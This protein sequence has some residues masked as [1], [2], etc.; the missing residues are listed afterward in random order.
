MFRYRQISGN[1]GG[2]QSLGISH[3]IIWQRL[4]V[5]Y[6][7]TDTYS[8]NSPVADQREKEKK[9]EAT[10]RLYACSF[11]L[12]LCLLPSSQPVTADPRSTPSSVQFASCA[13]VPPVGTFRDATEQKCCWIRSFSDGQ[14]FLSKVPQM[15]VSRPVPCSNSSSVDKPRDVISIVAG[16]FSQIFWLLQMF[17]TSCSRV[18]QQIMVM[19][20]PKFLTTCVCDV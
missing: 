10:S 5:A 3:V 2:S 1:L 12:R 18:Q 16:H 17:L 15:S 19:T 8:N 20:P 6:V 7:C 11:G 4:C 14:F 13:T 9:R